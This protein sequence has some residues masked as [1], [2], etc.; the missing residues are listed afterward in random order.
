MAYNATYGTSD[1]SAMFVDLIGNGL[2]QVIAFVG[3]IV[4]IFLIAYIVKLSKKVMK[5]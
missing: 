3:L 4:L 1:L 5:G 2:F